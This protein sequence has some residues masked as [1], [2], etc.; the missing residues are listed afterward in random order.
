[1]STILLVDKTGQIKEQFFKDLSIC[2]LYKKCNYRKLD[3]NFCQKCKWNIK[4]KKT[5]YC[6]CIYGKSEGKANNENKYEIPPPY[7]KNLLFGTIAIVNLKDD[8]IGSI[9]EELWNILYE[10]LYGGFEDLDA[11]I[12]E[13]EN[14]IDELNDVDKKDKT[15]SG[16]LKDSFVVD[17]DSN[18]NSSDSN[19]IS[20]DGESLNKSDSDEDDDDDDDDDDDSD[21]SLENEKELKEEMYV[22]SDDEDD[23]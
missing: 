11:T 10:K 18:I 1:M 9:T 5:S 6:I 14:E 22:F 7:D 23:N 4:Y 15:K 2:E 3:E 12:E 16:Y 21:D 17:D 20:T 19:D 8:K 13:D